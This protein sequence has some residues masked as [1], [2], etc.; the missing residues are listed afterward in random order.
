MG[1]AG[2]ILAFSIM[3]V[4]LVTAL[5]YQRRRM[6][7]YCTLFVPVIGLVPAVARVYGTRPQTSHG[8]RSLNTTS[9]G[10]LGMTL[11]CV[12]NP[13]A[14]PRQL[15]P[16]K[17][18][19]VLQCRICNTWLVGLSSRWNDARLLCHNWKLPLAGSTVPLLLR[20]LLRP[21]GPCSLA[22]TAITLRM[23]NPV[24]SRPGSIVPSVYSSR[25]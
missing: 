13:D 4:S 5:P 22:L 8:C 2:V 15:P 11:L 21:K 18:P 20:L 7:R 16:P 6:V 25:A 9:V 12:K 17:K 1:S 24:L 3:V 23:C 14:S 19:C 10:V